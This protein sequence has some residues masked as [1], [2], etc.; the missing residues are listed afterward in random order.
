[1]VHNYK[2]KLGEYFRPLGLTTGELLY[3]YKIFKGF[4]ISIDFNL[5]VYIFK[6]CAPLGQQ[7][8]NS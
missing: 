6:F 8:N 7:L 1:M 5:K 3:Y 2:K 4:M